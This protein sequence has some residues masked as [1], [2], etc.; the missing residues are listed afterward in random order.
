VVVQDFGRV[1]AGTRIEFSEEDALSESTVR[2]IEAL[3]DTGVSFYFTDGICV[4]EAI[5]ARPGGFRAW[6]NIVFDTIENVRYYSYEASLVVL[7]E[8]STGTMTTT[9]TTTTSSTTTTTTAP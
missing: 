9:T 1:A 8:I 2:A 4:W 7:D 3:I 5:F 6:P